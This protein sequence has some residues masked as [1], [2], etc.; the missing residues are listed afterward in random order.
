MMILKS[1]GKKLHILDDRRTE[2]KG[3]GFPIGMC[4]YY[5]DNR[6]IMNG[7]PTCS[8]CI[9]INNKREDHG[10]DWVDDGELKGI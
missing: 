2:E 3:K 10:K 6:N 9:K 1:N 7:T 8:R 4:G 5:G